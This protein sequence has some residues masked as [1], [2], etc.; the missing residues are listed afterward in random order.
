M[1]D[2][3]ANAAC[4]I[5]ATAANDSNDGLFHARC[6]ESLGPKRIDFAFNLEAPW[7][8]EKDKEFPLV[9]TYLC[10][11]QHLAQVC[12]ESAPLNKRAWVSQERQ[13]SNRTLHFTSTQLFWECN[14][15]LACEIYP[16][17]LPPWARAF[18]RWDATSLKKRVRDIMHEGKDNPSNFLTS[19]SLARGLDEDTHFAW[20]TF[21]DQYSR[22]ALTHETDKLVAIQG[23]AK[24]VGQA[25]GDEL[26][27]GLWLSR[28][29]EELCWRT[30]ASSSKPSAWR[31]PTWS[32]ACIDGEIFH[33]LLTKFHRKHASRQMEAR[34]VEINVGAELSGELK[35]AS[36]SIKCR[37]LRVTFTSDGWDWLP[38]RQPLQCSG[39]LEL[40]DRNG[41]NYRPPQR[42]AVGPTNCD[43]ELSMEGR[44][45]E[46]TT[47]QHGYV[48]VLQRCVHSQECETHDDTEGSKSKAEGD[49]IDFWGQDSTE[50]L[51]LRARDDI[52]FERVGLVSFYRFRAVS[53]ILTA[54]GIA[55]ERVVTLT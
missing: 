17:K 50:A 41:E 13:L 52:T 48:V 37:P 55:E 28:I 34:L 54:H 39:T 18:W 35:H 31:A 29:I 25:T 30:E 46:I 8:K 27:A 6:P 36:I 3:F 10:E 4:T 40:V 23:I 22:C 53:Q 47:P 42:F 12:I 32:W 7:L 26:V 49:D 21:R 44:A 24:W 9:G 51:F 33:S 19:T 2:V 45:P 11:I 15:R 38:D 20:L 1:G 14:E 43:V 16:E 5:A